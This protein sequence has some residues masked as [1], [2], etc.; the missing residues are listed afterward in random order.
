MQRAS[1][2]IRLLRHV[3]PAVSCLV[4]ANG[5][6]RRILGKIP[7]VGVRVNYILYYPAACCLFSRSSG[8]FLMPA[9]PSLEK[10]ELNLPSMDFAGCADDSSF[11]PSVHGCRDGFDF[12]LKF[13]Q[14]FFSI[15]PS[16]IFIALGLPRLWLLLRR[17]CVVDGV[18]FQLTK[19][20]SCHHSPQKVCSH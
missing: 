14:I 12:T 7:V 1:M 19:A 5:G 15:L 17:P 9:S 3:G 11:G 4:A 2:Q 13:E 16:S 10:L 20:V 18:W 6:S 8:P